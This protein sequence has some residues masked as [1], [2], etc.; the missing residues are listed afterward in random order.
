V[1]EVGAN[2]ESEALDLVATFARCPNYPKERDGLVFFARG[3]V[4]AADSH[5]VNMSA[6]VKRCAA[7]SVYCPT[8]YDLICAAASIR[9]ELD[10]A[11]DERKTARERFETS[12]LGILNLVKR[13]L[14]APRCPLCGSEELYCEYGGPIK[15]RRAHA[16][17]GHLSQQPPVILI[18]M[19]IPHP[20]DHPITSEDVQR[21]VEELHKKNL[22][23]EVADIG[24]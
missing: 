20:I 9:D 23:K 12:E 14:L 8:D 16:Y 7:N 24:H 3:L 21:A 11:M 18:P 1:P 19:P 15:H 5:R 13:G 10:R 6:I 2:S 17:A 4:K 22:G